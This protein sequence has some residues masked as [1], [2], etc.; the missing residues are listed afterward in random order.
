MQSNN[1]NTDK[2]VINNN[3]IINLNNILNNVNISSSN[4]NTQNADLISVYNV[5]NSNII[6]N[7]QISNQNISNLIN[8]FNNINTNENNQQ[9]NDKIIVKNLF[10]EY[11]LKSTY[12]KRKNIVFIL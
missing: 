2:S 6:Q 8:I 11:K 4:K 7:N 10:K 5:N 9:P 3:S 12:D 1:I